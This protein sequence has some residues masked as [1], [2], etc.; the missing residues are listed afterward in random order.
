MHSVVYEKFFAACH[1]DL[2]TL[3][4]RGT[5]CRLEQEKNKPH[6]VSEVYGSLSSV[7]AKLLTN[8]LSPG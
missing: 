1:P 7:A 8:S 4:H 2:C 5:H 6:Q 3:S